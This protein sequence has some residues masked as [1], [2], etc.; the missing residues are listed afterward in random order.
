MEK[1]SFDKGQH[2]LIDFKTPGKLEIEGD[3]L[4]LDMY[5]KSIANI[6]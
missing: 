2:P 1:K 6:T 4:S 3:F 5:E